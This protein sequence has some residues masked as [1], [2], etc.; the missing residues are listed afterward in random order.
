MNEK[1]KKKKQTA[2]ETIKIE[3]GEK[4]PLVNSLAVYRYSAE[5]IR[6]GNSKQKCRYET[7]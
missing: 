3:E 7:S 5:D 2:E 6:K 4:V 1:E